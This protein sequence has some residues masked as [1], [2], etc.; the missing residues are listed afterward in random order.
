[1][2]RNSENVSLWSHVLLDFLFHGSSPSLPSSC[3]SNCPS[4]FPPVCLSVCL[5]YRAQLASQSCVSLLTGVYRWGRVWTGPR[6]WG[7]SSK[8]QHCSSIVSLHLPFVPECWCM[9]ACVRAWKPLQAETSHHSEISWLPQTTAAA[10]GAAA[11]SQN[12]ERTTSQPRVCRWVICENVIKIQ[13]S[14]TDNGHMQSF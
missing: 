7:T 14:P 11:E 13:L 6:I 2:W 1:M 9:C 8:L 10:A 3:L 12:P 5:A 4:P